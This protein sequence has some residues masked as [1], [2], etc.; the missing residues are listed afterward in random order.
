M[1]EDSYSHF[2]E[3]CSLSNIQIA[4]NNAQT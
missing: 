4:V 3:A 2:L 1:V